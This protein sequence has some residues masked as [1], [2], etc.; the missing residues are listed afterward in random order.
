[1][2]KRITTDSLVWRLVGRLATCVAMTIAGLLLAGASTA[3][4]QTLRAY[5]DSDKW[6]ADKNGPLLVLEPDLVVRKGSGTGLEAFDRKKMAVRG[7][8]AI[9]PTTMVLIDDSFEHSPSMYDGLPLYA[10]IT[11]LLSTLNAGQWKEITGNGIGLGDLQGEQCD[12]FKS[13]LPDPFSWMA[14]RNNQDG[15]GSSS[16]RPADHAFAYLRPGVALA[17]VG[18]RRRRSHGG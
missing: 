10:K 11:Y 6:D 2:G 13:I 9:V 15:A 8:T 12:V 4:E 17:Q 5:L 3:Q 1:M 7:L 16:P 18:G 14:Y